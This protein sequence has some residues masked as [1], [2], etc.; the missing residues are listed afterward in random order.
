LVISLHDEHV[1]FGQPAIELAKS[2]GACLHLKAQIP[3]LKRHHHVNSKTTTGS[4]DVDGGQNP[5]KDGAA[6]KIG[7]TLAY[8]SAALCRRSLGGK[9]WLGSKPCQGRSRRRRGP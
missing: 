9:R 7:M 1:A 2:I 5:R 6:K 3:P 8:T 4:T